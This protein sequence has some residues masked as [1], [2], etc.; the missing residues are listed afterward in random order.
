MNDET[1]HREPARDS[2]STSP[3]SSDSVEFA[4][5]QNGKR[6]RMSAEEKVLLNSTF[7]EICGG[8]LPFE[9]NPI[10]LCDGPKCN[11]AY[12]LH[13]LT[14]PLDGVPEGDF[15]GPCCE[16][17]KRTQMK[18]STVGSGRAHMRRMRLMNRSTNRDSIG[19]M[20]STI[21]P[22][23]KLP[24]EGLF[25]QFSKSFSTRNRRSST[26]NLVETIDNDEPLYGKRKKPEELNNRNLRS[27]S[28]DSAESLSV[29]VPEGDAAVPTTATSSSSSH[30]DENT[31]MSLVEQAPSHNWHKSLME[32]HKRLIEDLQPIVG[33]ARIKE[34]LI[35]INCK[36]NL[37][38]E[39]IRRSLSPV[40]SVAS[41]TH[42]GSG[43]APHIALIGNP[44]TGKSMIGRILAKMLYR[45][46]AIKRN[47]FVKAHRSDLVAGYL[48]QTS[49]KTSQLI[50][51]A[52]GGIMFIDEAHQLINPNKEDYGIEAYRE[53]MKEM[54]SDHAVD[55]DRVTFIF[56][57]YPRQM[58]RFL[59]HDAGMESRISFRITLPDYS[60]SELGM[61][62]ESKMMSRDMT[63]GLPTEMDPSVDIEKILGML[64]EE[65]V[66]RY[67]ARISDLLLD[68]AEA[69][70]AR[71]MLTSE[72]VPEEVD[73]F[74]L[75]E[76]DFRNAV[77][78][79]RYEM[80]QANANR[81]PDSSESEN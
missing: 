21:G 19:S 23:A 43:M 24:I 59:N 61:I 7:C 63:E 3:N 53:I 32:S 73:I 31:S 57:G 20:N 69:S 22:S 56:A 49:L 41:S 4:A 12:H 81:S 25:S 46:H 68:K 74:K 52:R 15:L 62:C 17:S 6:V 64:P 72:S 45:A 30:E 50:E 9:K 18:A 79:L 36:I 48:G 67:N 33:M 16:A 27:L 13:C 54:L 44:G 77:V 80:L 60:L 65:L 5:F 11:K 37:R 8:M 35:D 34:L 40:S 51:Q 78:N 66:P 71:R 58:N 29:Q 39:R 2:D 1:P 28:R 47:V 76:I 70:L 42:M 10:V 26:S 75:S 14:P 38:K 55:E